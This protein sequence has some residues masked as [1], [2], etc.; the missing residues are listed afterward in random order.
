MCLESGYDLSSG[1]AAPMAVDPPA[2]IVQLPPVPRLRSANFPRLS[3]SK[4]RTSSDEVAAAAQPSAE[5]DEED[6]D[7][8]EEDD[9]SVQEVPIS[10]VIEVRPP[11]A[12]L[13][14]RGR[15][16]V[17][18][19]VD[20]P[21]IQFTHIWD[22]K[23]PRKL[24]IPREPSPEAPPPP[25]RISSRLAKGKTASQPSLSPVKK[26]TGSSKK[27]SLSSLSARIPMPSASQLSELLRVSRDLA[28][29][30]FRFSFL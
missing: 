20:V 7:E 16:K 8:I 30:R 14:T 18:P 26:A 27:R 1:F 2:G 19:F 13:P 6:E 25:S 15:T 5:D 24:L 23:N 21:S 3:A 17:R 29:V 22:G 12:S 28:P 10:D 4:V 9:D 11:P